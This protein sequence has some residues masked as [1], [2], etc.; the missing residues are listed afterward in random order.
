MRIS[1]TDWTD[2][3]WTIEDSVAL[4]AQ[5]GDRGVDLID[6]SS[7]GNV[8]QATI[9]LGPGYQVPFAERI[10]RETGIATGAVGLITEPHQAEAIVR[11]GQ[12]DVV[13][14]ARELL[15]DPYWPLHAA[16]A[17]GAPAPVPD[18]VSSGVL[19]RADRCTRPTDAEDRVTKRSRP[20]SPSDRGLRVLRGLER[21]RRPIGPR[22]KGVYC[23]GRP[24]GAVVDDDPA[25]R[26]WGV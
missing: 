24:R 17:L 22:R 7:G 4:A 12:A 9:P 18:P 5:L 2:G 6:C 20:S 16:S 10:R 13:L 8:A 1:A 14:L 3:G 21:S 26:P 11:D 25:W 19:M 15:R 23:K